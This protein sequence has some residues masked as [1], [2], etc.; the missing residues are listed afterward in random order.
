MP[1]LDEVELCE[2]IR[3]IDNTVQIIFITAFEGYYDDPE[4]TDI[5]YLQ[6]PFG[7]QEIIYIVNMVIAT[8]YTSYTSYIV[9]DAITIQKG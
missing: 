9:I 5:N 8:K 6:K 3:E 4:L 7:N 2:K 1:V